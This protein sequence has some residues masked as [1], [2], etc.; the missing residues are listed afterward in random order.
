LTRD[1]WKL[2]LLLATINFIHILDFVIVMPL[3]DQLRE[4]LSITPRQFGNIVS[5]YGLTAMLAWIAAATVIDR[6]DRRKTM[7]LS[8]AGFVVTT[9]YCGLASDYFHLLIARGLAGLC[10]GVVVC[11]HDGDGVWNIHDCSFHCA[12]LRSQLRIVVKSPADH[13]CGCR[14]VL[15]VCDEHQ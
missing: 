5:A 14:R 11:I 6:F 8:L 2:V 3:G 9:L 7:L 15:A 1:E 13:R 12:L 10:G 4:E